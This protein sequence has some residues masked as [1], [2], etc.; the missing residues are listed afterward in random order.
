[1]PYV[2]SQQGSAFKKLA[3]TWN[4]DIF[5]IAYELVNSLKVVL[6]NIQNQIQNSGYSY[7]PRDQETLAQPDLEKTLDI[8]ESLWTQKS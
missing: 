8:E 2:Y 1:M 6:H 5:C 4:K 3:Q 7:G